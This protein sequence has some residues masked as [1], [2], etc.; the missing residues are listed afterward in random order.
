V[1]A[2]VVSDDVSLA[3]G[4]S[5]YD[6]Y[7]LEPAG[8]ESPVRPGAAL[9]LAEN[10]RDSPGSYQLRHRLEVD[11]GQVR[12]GAFFLPFV[13]LQPFWHLDA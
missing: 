7:D 1:T 6:D 12:E 10:R 3:S 9:C 8:S 11:L 2:A 13:K 5:S 4:A